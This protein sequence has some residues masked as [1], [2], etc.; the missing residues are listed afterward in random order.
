MYLEQTEPL[1]PEEI[2][3]ELQALVEGDPDGIACLANA[4]A[5]LS[6]HVPRINWVGFYLQRGRD[7]VLGPF[8][9]K[10]ACTRIG[11]GRGVCGASFARGE[12]IVVDD[13]LTFP[14]HIACD[15]A[16]RSEIVVPLVVRSQPIGV[17]DCDAPV[18][19]RFGAEERLLFE[20][21]ARIVGAWLEAAEASV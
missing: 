4:A 12:T 7:L 16:S 15:A 21:A 6:L 10:P 14:D 2:L 19:A 20:G 11:P 5:L 8:Q 17:L 9:G 13:V 3:Q 1:A 18:P